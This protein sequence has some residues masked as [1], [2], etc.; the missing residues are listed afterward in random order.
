MTLTGHTS[1]IWSMIELEDGKIL[2]GA[3]DRKAIVWNLQ[4]QKEEFTLYEG[5]NEIS[6]V[7]Q[8]KSGKVLTGSGEPLLRIWN[9]DSKSQEGDIEAK[10]G[11]WFMTEL[12]DGT[13]AAGM[14]NGDIQIYDIEKKKIVNTLK[15]H[16]KTINCMVEIEPGRIVSGSDEEDMILWNLNDISAKYILK[17]HKGP[18]TAIVRLNEGRFLSASKDKT[19]KLWE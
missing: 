8:V 4:E 11:V 17:G 12:S 7:L 5:K 13:V 18:I 2:S 9:L 14:G 19:I 3:D 6:S 1:M 16:K 15:G 10:S